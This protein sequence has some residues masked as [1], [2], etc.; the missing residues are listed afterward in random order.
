MFSTDGRNVALDEPP[1]AKLQRGGMGVK[2]DQSRRIILGSLAGATTTAWAGPFSATTAP[3]MSSR[4]KDVGRKFFADGR[5]RPFA[6]N[7]IVCHLPQQDAGFESF[8]AILRIYRDL[9]SH[10]FSRKLAILP[11]SSYHMTIFGGANDQDRLSGLWPRDLPVDAPLSAC[12]AH[13]A[14]KLMGIDPACDLPIRMRV[15]DSE[16]AAH[17]E[18]LLIDLAPLDAAEDRKL[19]RLR[20]LLSRVLQIRAADHDHYAFHISIAYQTA[21]FDAE[22]E[23]EYASV[24]RRWIAELKNHLPEIR[25]GAP[26]FCTFNDMFAFRSRLRIV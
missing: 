26:E 17:P 8:D 23:K 10:D 7:T 16:P 12:N 18:P 3:P 22:E 6:G 5:V 20:D 24:R 14:A 1:A 2:F 11:P 9:R 15:D 19:R 25:L 13:L 21:W 4:P